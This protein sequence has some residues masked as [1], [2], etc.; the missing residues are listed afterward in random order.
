MTMKKFTFSIICM[1][2]MIFA[3]AIIAGASD[4][5]L[6]KNEDGTS[7][8]VTG[9]G[10]YTN[11]DIIIP[12]S[13]EG[14]P[15]TEIA[16]FAFYDEEKIT[17]VY[18]PNTITR[19]GECA[20]HYCI[21]LRSV[22]IDG[23]CE[24]GRE[25]FY[26]CYRIKEL[27]LGT[28]VTKIG[29]YAFYNCTGLNYLII[30]NSTTLI[31]NSAFDFCYNLV[32]VTIGSGVTEIGASAF[33]LCYKI[34]EVYN[35]SKLDIQPK[36]SDFGGVA[37]RAF[38]VH[39]SIEA[40][41]ILE[42]IADGYVFAYYDETYYLVNQTGN[43]TSL[44]LPESING[45]SYE[46]NRFAFAYRT[47]LI[48]VD[49]SSGVTFIGGASFYYC[50]A[51][52]EIYIPSSVTY[53]EDLAFSDCHSL[54]SAVFG[55]GVSGMG[56]A[57]FQN[58]YLLTDVI[59]SNNIPVIDFACFTSCESLTNINMPKN[60]I[61][62]GES[63]FYSCEALTSIFIP[64]G[65]KSIGQYAFGECTGLKSIV[66][67]RSVTEIGEVAFYNCSKLNIYCAG[68]SEGENW[69]SGW[70]PHKCPVTWNYRI[71]LEDAFIFKGYSTDGTSICVGY[72]IDSNVLNE[73]KLLN[74]G[75]GTYGIVLAS[76]EMLDGKNPLD[77]NGN[78]IAL[79][80][81]RVALSKL[82]A[83]NFISYDIILNDITE[84]Y[85][86]HSFVMAVF[87]CENGKVTY[88]QD[89]NS[90]TASGI[91][92]QAILNELNSSLDVGIGSLEL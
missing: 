67:P 40:E 82:N 56:I 39:S 27:N 87:T 55:N 32:Q 50:G 77:E 7:Y 74:E 26:F 44:S 46:I 23:P 51:L 60:L 76:Y 31:G 84:E 45:S 66:I 3:F 10:D 19:I 53:V 38:A 79:E 63:A 69:H 8:S 83:D 37:L 81:S 2:I 92:Y 18:I 15:V 22:S 29:D 21:S 9:L 70:N 61:S 17:S 54:K 12:S 64:S 52:E 80:N 57:V 48:S 14:L 72:G 91:S 4:L 58:C 59:L 65:A 25:A 62:I 71:K 11:T 6:T 28:Q 85:Y 41:S 89:S 36:S 68:S 1:L 33:E 42:E 88:V 5:E 49:I 73:Y 35:L 47:D 16:D 13:Y 20:F 90:D 86:S 43:E 75:N 78:P 24:I 30:P 34:S